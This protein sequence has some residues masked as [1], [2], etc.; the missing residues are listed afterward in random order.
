MPIS[1]VLSQII[2]FLIQFIFLL[3]VLLYSYI[4]GTLSI[5]INFSVFLIPIL[6]I[7]MT[8]LSLGCG[9]IISSL[10]TKYRDLAMLVSFGTQLWMYAS[11]VVYSTSLLPSS[12]LNIYMLNPMAPILDAFRYS[13]LGIGSLQI[14]YYFISWIITLMILFLG[15]VLF[16]RVEKNFMDTI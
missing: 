4:N 15:V 7:Q 1:T 11:P 9:I 14:K 13:C 8:L 6:L 3:I 12:F 10:T 16:N 2:S 5:N